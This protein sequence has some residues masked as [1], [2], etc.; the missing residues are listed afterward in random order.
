MKVVDPKVSSRFLSLLQS[1]EK[2]GD[3][4]FVVGKDE[5]RVKAHKCIVA[6]SSPALERM[7]FGTM[8]EATKKEIRFVITN[9]RFL[10]VVLGDR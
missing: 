10:F 1:T 7:L 3:I 2:T 9:T 6:N 4:T 8:V 5:T